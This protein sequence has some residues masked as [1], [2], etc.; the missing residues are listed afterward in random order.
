MGQQCHGLMLPNGTTVVSTK[1][2][3]MV[4]LHPQTVSRDPS[5]SQHHVEKNR[6]HFSAYPESIDP[7]KVLEVPGSVLTV[8]HF[9]SQISQSK[10]IPSWRGHELKN[11]LIH[12][13]PVKKLQDLRWNFRF[14]MTWWIVIGCRALS[15]PLN[16]MHILKSQ[17]SFCPKPIL[18]TKSEPGNRVKSIMRYALFNITFT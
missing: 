15:I 4:I 6:G 18:S 10:T 8:S 13:F 5:E 14:V 9:P 7:R 1:H 3:Q 16:F 17:S 11:G 2:R 12:I